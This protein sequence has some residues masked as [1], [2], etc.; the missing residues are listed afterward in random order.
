MVI[1]HILIGNFV[2]TNKME[3]MEDLGFD[4]GGILSEEEA[5]KLFEEQT[6]TAEKAEESEEKLENEPTEGQ[7]E[8]HE[9]ETVGEEDD[10]N[11]DNAIVPEGD[12]SSPANI[13]SSIASALKN[14]GIF[15]DFED[16]DLESVKTA[17]DFAELFEKAVTSRLDERQRR[18]DEA[19]GNG[20]QPDTVKMYEQTISYLDSIEEDALSAETQEGEDLRKRVIYNDLINRGYSQDRAKRELEKSFKSGSDVD[21][22][23]DAL[24]A[25]KTF[26]KDGY[27]KV[28]NEAKA[29]VESFKKEQAKQA[30]GFKKMILEDEMKIGDTVLDKKTCQRVFDAVSKPIYKDPDTGRLLTAVQKFQKEKPLEFL[31]QLGMWFVLTDGGKNADGFTKKQLRAEKNKAIKELGNKINTSSLNKDGSL[32]YASGSNFTGEDPLLSDDWKIGW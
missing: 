32:G 17:D 23:K 26:Y 16:K 28:Q 6:D 24:D 3:K 27:E 18:I 2:Q 11:G 21:D 20:V 13:Y 19:L 9:P 1:Q 15:P 7:E 12:G 29:K 10:E 14:D 5:A 30:D 31:K 22:A 4:I 8:T 25:L